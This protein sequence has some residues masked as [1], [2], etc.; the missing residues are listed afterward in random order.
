MK[1]IFKTRVWIVLSVLVAASSGI[2]TQTARDAFHINYTYFPSVGL[3][4]N[5]GKVEAQQF[6]IFGAMEPIRLSNRINFTNVFYYRNTQLNYDETFLK[7]NTFPRKIHDIRYMPA[8]RIQMNPRWNFIMLP[9]ILLRSDLDH[10]FSVTDFI[11]QSGFVLSYNYT[12][13][14]NLKVGFGGGIGLFEFK[15]FRFWPLIQFNYNK[16]KVKCEIAL[17]YANITYNITKDLEAGIFAMVDNSISTVA[18]FTFENETVTHLRIFQGIVA[19]TVSYLLYRNFYGHI[20]FGGLAPIRQLLPL[21]QD[22]RTI[23]VLKFGPTSSLFFK[24]G[25]SYRRPE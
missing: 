18:P 25:V 7:Q 21:D 3:T 15:H 17:P 24:I 20:K 5:K 19:P 11:A 14:Y 6:D 10:P 16:R 4:Q 22:F 2:H 1:G 9:K 23:D 13:E 12:G 8:F